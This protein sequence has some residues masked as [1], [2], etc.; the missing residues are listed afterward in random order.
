MQIGKGVASATARTVLGGSAQ[1]FLRRVQPL[2]RFVGVAAGVM[3]DQASW[4]R[5]NGFVDLA[6]LALASVSPRWSSRPVGLGRSVCEISA[7]LANSLWRRG[8]W[9]F[10]PI[11]RCFSSITQRSCGAACSFESG[12]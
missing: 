11:H 10:D 12:G 4:L 7:S 9:L 3:R 2:L 1:L 5:T 6:S 8:L